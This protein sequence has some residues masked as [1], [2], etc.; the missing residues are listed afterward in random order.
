MMPWLA[1]GGGGAQS[2]DAWNREI[3][4]GQTHMTKNIIFPQPQPT[5]KSFQYYFTILLI[6][7]I[8]IEYIDGSPLSACG[9]MPG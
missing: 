2:H 7:R 4:C 1:G 9:C 6:F 3:P 8:Y 5:A